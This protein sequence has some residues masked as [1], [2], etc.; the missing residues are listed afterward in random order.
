MTLDFIVQVLVGKVALY[1]FQSM[2]SNV[3]IK[4]RFIQTLVRCD[5]CL[6][7]WLYVGLAWAFGWGEINGLSSIPILNAFLVGIGVSFVMH[8]ITL[9]WK[10][11]YETFIIQND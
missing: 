3:E 8:L 6:G 11:K 1:A 10:A 7:C 9:G 4:K 5:F 2:M